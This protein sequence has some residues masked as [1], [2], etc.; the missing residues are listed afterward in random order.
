MEN[1]DN[2]FI[3]KISFGS[4]GSELRFVTIRDGNILNIA[5][6]AKNLNGLGK[7]INSEI[8]GNANLDISEFPDVGLSSFI[9]TQNDANFYRGIQSYVLSGIDAK[10]VFLDGKNAGVFYED[11]YAQYALIGGL[12]AK[13]TKVSRDIQTLDVFE[14][15][16]EALQSVGMDFSNVGRTWFYNDDILDWYDVFNRARDKFFIKNEVFDNLVPA[17]TGVGSRNRK[18]S[19]LMARVFAVK[20]KDSRVSF[21]VVP[22]PMQCPAPDYRSSFSRAVELEHPNF[23]H[24]LVSGT[25]SIEQGGATAFVGDIDKQIGL[26]LDVIEAILKSR[27]MDWN[28]SLRVVAY[29]KD[30]S[31]EQNFLKICKKRGLENMPWIWVQSDV[32]RDDLLFE[33]ELDAAVSV[34]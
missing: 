8:Y 11:E 15:M 26:T 6:H 32:C 30:F 27:D 3:K 25:A 2:T 17:S 12:L 1:F 10:D 24:L 33:I 28:D 16:Q 19:A 5:Q 21:K 4:K 34:K 18:G 20:P 29:L 13:D 23:R 31:Y 22:S 7:V 14:Q 9:G